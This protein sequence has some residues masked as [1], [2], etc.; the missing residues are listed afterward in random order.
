MEDWEK[1][2][3]KMLRNKKVK[4]LVECI[5]CSEIYNIKDFDDENPLEVCG[6]CGAMYFSQMLKLKGDL[7]VSLNSFLSG[8]ICYTLKEL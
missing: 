1:R 5:T 7:F 3:I 4:D 2:N 8:G 6:E